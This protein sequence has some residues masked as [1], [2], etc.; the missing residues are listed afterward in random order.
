MSDVCEVLYSAGIRLLEV[1]LNSPDACAS[2]KIAAD[3]YHADG[4]ML[5]G[6]GTVLTPEDVRNVAAAG[7]KFI[8]SPDT[9]AEVIAE[10]KRLGLISIPG[11]FT[12]TEAFAALRAGADYLK[13]FPAGVNG[14]GYIKDIKAVIKAP[15]LAVGG[16]NTGNIPEFLTLCAGVGIGSALY[17]PGKSL[18]DI[19]KTAAEMVAAAKKQEC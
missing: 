17:K 2:I 12:P 14:V 16:V 4:T 15:I 6:A 19:R 1:P 5:I 9:N 7:G 10:T 11:F 3:K 13:L 18:E 8:I